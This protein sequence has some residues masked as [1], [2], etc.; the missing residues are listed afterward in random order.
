MTQISIQVQLQRLRGGTRP[1]PAQ[2]RRRRL[3]WQSPAREQDFSDDDRSSSDHEMSCD[4]EWVPETS[5]ASSDDGENIG[6]LTVLLILPR[7]H[8]DT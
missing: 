3:D 7:S 4:S 6:R 1:E 5:T 2:R 8:S